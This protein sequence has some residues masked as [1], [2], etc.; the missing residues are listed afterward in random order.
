[1]AVA[2]DVSLADHLVHLLISQ[3]LA[4]VGHYV[5]QL[6]RRDESVAVAV[7]DLEGLD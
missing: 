4:Q 7:E 6:S 1:V 2:V 3:L 5:P